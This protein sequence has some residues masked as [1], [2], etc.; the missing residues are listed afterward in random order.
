MTQVPQR[1]IHQKHKPIRDPE[2][3]RHVASQPCMSCGHHQSQA[4]HI[5]VGN[6]ARGMKADDSLCIP[7]CDARPDYQGCHAR[8]DRNQAS[9]ALVG[10]H[11]ITIDELKEFAIAKYDE[12]K[13]S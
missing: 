9:F 4:A 6:F 1:P 10:L 5:S 12:W 11:G 3:R 8:F 7:L 2:Y 13:A